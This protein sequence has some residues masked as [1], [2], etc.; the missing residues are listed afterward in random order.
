MPNDTAHGIP[1]TLYNAAGVTDV[2]FTMAYNPSILTISGTLQGAGCDATDAAAT[3]TLL[4]NAGGLATFN[5]HDATPHS[6]T[7]VLGDVDAT[8]PASA[9]NLYQVKQLLQLGSIVINNGAITSAVSANGVDINAYIG[10]VSG[11]GKISGLDVL[12][13]NQVAIGAATGFDAYKLM[14]P[15]LL[16]DV[17]GD[18]CCDAGNVAALD[19]FVAQLHPPQ[20]SSSPGTGLSLR[21]TRPIRR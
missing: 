6:G 19:L 3:F 12:E 20:D 5:F 10:D 17:T 14:D 8:V 4:G 18:L 11:D 2:T 21:Q 13:A 7:L 1:I 9:N 15:V 16:S